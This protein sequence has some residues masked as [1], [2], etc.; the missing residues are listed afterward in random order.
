[1][2]LHYSVRAARSLVTEQ[3]GV[4]LLTGEALTC[5]STVSTVNP[6]ESRGSYSAISNNMKLVHWLLMGGLFVNWTKIKTKVKRMTKKSLMDVEEQGCVSS[7]FHVYTYI[8]LCY[9][10]LCLFWKLC[11]LNNYICNNNGVTERVSGWVMSSMDF[12]NGIPYH[13]LIWVI[14]D[15]GP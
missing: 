1:M 8:C 12:R 5:C 2:A 11:K 6:L 10:H 13:L 14:L 7:V 4:W 9:V 3:D 15:Y